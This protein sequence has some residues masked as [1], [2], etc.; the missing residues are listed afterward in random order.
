M[1]EAL[2]QTAGPPQTK[3]ETLYQDLQSLI[4]G[5]RPNE[6]LEPLERA[7]RFASE[8]HRE[9]KRFSGEP[10][11]I[12]PLLVT[13][14]LAEMNMDM[15]CLQTGLLHDVVE[16]TSAKI[17]D[18]RKIFGEDVARCVDGVTKLSK[19]N[20]ASREARQAERVRQMLLA[21]VNDPPVI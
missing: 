17:E 9:Q 2:A 1:L 19:L 4:H 15:V 12:H 3:V 16:D 20:L 5:L 11:M 10:Y 8:R 13:H 6:D 14:Q 7:Y 18:I 21:M